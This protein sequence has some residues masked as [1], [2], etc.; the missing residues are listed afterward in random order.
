M[1]QNVGGSGTDKRFARHDAPLFSHTT[2]G[3]DVWIGHGV[4]IKTGITVGDGAVIG[5]GSV[6]TKDVPPY[7]VVAGVPA[8]VLR[9]RFDDN[10]IDALQKLRWWEWDD[11]KLTECGKYI[12]NPTEFIRHFA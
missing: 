1:F 12:T 8:R 11:E 9:Y 2:I 7:S 3:N 4:T 6:V 10:T 5:S